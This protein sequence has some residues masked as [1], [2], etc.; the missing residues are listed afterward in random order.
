MD[1]KESRVAILILNYNSRPFL[2][3]CLTS[4]FEQ[5]YKNFEIFLIDNSSTD[6]SLGLVKEKF[7]NLQTIENPQNY[8][9]GRGFNEGIKFV[10]NDFEYIGILNPDIRADKR[11]LE[12]SVSTLKVHSNAQICSSLSVDWEGRFIDGAGGRIINFLGGIFGG[13]LGGISMQDIPLENKNHDFKVFFGIA[14]A[15]V[16]KADTFNKF[17][18]FDE[19]YFMYF[20]DI[21]FSW[22]VLLAGGEIWC[23]PKSIV[24]H[25]GHGSKMQKEIQLKILSATETNLLA[26]YLKNLSFTTLILVLPLLL[27]IRIIISFLYLFISPKITYSKLKGVTLFLLRLFLG[28]Y[29]KQRVLIQ[30]LRKINDR[31][32]LLL[33]P[34]SLFSFSEVIRL[35]FPWVRRIEEVYK[36]S[37]R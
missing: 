24:Y 7:P 9:F 12:E 18:F 28:K 36:I 6:G 10:L 17:G 33:N 35:I 31:Q 13:Y 27:F 2:E 23:N 14:T 11:W 26:T 5:T 1:K 3:D 34:G 29:T 15:I 19:S 20:E 25:Y 21:D 37:G 22:R 30:K 4:L 16:A 32:L 8:G